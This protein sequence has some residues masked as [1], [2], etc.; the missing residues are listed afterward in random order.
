MTL[1]MT[2]LV[3]A[4]ELGPLERAPLRL[5]LVQA[6]TAPVLAMERPQTIERLATTLDGWDLI[7]HQT[8]VELAV[9]LSPQGVEQQQGRPETVWVLTSS[10]DQFR[11]VVSASSVSVECE[12]YSLWP[13]FQEAVGQLFAAVAEVAAPSRCTRL[14]VRYVNELR[15]DARLTGDPARMTEL[16]SEE[17]LAVAVAL[18]RP[19]AG[20]SAELRVEE[21]W[22]TLALRHGLIE[23]GRFLLDLDAYNEQAQP[24]DAARMLGQAGLFHARIESVF[25]WAITPTYLEELKG[26]GHGQTG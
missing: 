12:H 15:D 10:G 26:A 1:V 7:D 6:R 5:A 9:K 25:A 11:A 19:V 14:G 21:E 22:G 24:F 4:T 18:G 23:P 16:V 17:L 3:E 8:N 2:R 13:A 20:S